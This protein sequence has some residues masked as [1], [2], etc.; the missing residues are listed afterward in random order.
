MKSS[1]FS[2]S[3]EVEDWTVGTRRRG[4][5]AVRDDL[6]QCCGWLMMVLVFVADGVVVWYSDGWRGSDDEGDKHWWFCSVA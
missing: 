6:T 5:I 1:P 3:I 4:V 2:G